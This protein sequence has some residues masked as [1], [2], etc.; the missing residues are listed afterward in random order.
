[1]NH[2]PGTP[3]PEF[4]VHPK[5]VSKS[6]SRKIE[7]KKSAN[8]EW[9]KKKPMFRG[10]KCETRKTYLFIPVLLLPM[11]QHEYKFKRNYN[12]V[13]KKKGQ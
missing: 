11:Y 2:K 3:T 10:Y 12:L 6:G 8:V 5:N 9:L 4:T 13:F 7:L 1:V